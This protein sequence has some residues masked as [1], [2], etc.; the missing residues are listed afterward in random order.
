MKLLWIRLLTIKFGMVTDTKKTSI[1]DKF[2]RKKYIGVCSCRSR[3][4]RVMM[5]RL[6]VRAAMYIIRKNTP[7]T[8]CSSW[9]SEK[10]TRMNPVTAVILAVS[11]SFQAL[12]AG[13]EK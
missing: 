7:H 9:M 1:R 5:I 11:D 8:V 6:L 2:F 4:I 13:K 10:P 12:S 3:V